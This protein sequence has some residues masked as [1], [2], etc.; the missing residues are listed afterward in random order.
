MGLTLALN[1]ARASLLANSNQIAVS[2]RNVAGANDPGYSRK[3]ATLVAGS[4]GGATVTITRAGDPALYA[5]T[6]NAS[7]DAARSDALLTGLTK[8]AQTVGDTEDPTAPAARLTALQAALQA[9]ANQP[10]NAQLA[11]DAVESAKALAG[12]LN[13]AADA[14]HAVRAEA[15]AGINASV[16]RINDLLVRF[17]AANRAVTKA[18]ALGGDSTD[19]LDDRDRILTAL[20]QEIGVTAVAREGGDMAL[21]TDGGV[22]LFERGPRSVAFSATTVFA[23][24]TV[25][26]GVTIDGVPVT[27]AASPMPLGSGRIAGLAALRDGAAVRY[28]AQLDALAGG[29][30]DAFAETD[31]SL[32]DEGPRA[33][34]FTAGG[35]ALLPTGA[36]RSGLAA[37]ISVNAAVDPAR[38][39]SV[40]L[41]R[42]GGMNGSDYIDPAAGEDAAYAGRLRGLLTGLSAARPVDPSLGLD[43]SAGLP[44]LAAASAGWLEAQRKEASTDASYQ[45]TLLTRANEAL[46]NVAGVNGDDET[47]LALQLERSYSASAKLL[48]VVNDLLKTLFD[49]VR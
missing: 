6:L 38:G 9:A 7:S 16:S 10:D 31:F 45:R 36:G 1:T 13:Q 5:R 22:T 34:L 12:S 37:S 47:A 44:D 23:A 20:S 30:I 11:R 40:A 27:G 17:D 28:E 35:R 19:A 15:D 43:T 21:Y 29:L 14:V 48:S 39:G 3:I 24:G 8:L 4:A 32:I 26:G 25:G 2:A 49:A 46:S 33:G 41:L 42:S 18:T